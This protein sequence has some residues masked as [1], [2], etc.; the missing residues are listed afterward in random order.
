MQKF[1]TDM[2]NDFQARQQKNLDYFNSCLSTLSSTVISNADS[3]KKTESKLD[4]ATQNISKL[5]TKL[6]S[7]KEI[8]FFSA[9]RYQQMHLNHFKL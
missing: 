4:V 5:E 3:L 9:K 6:D 8:L 2:H 1:Q 7:Q